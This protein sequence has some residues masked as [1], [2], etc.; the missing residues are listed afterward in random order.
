[1]IKTPLRW[2]PSYG[3]RGRLLSQ[4]G[5]PWSLPRLA[6]CGAGGCDRRGGA[7]AAV[8]QAATVNLDET[9]WRQE[10][11]RARLW[12]LVTAELTVF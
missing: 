10:Q 11:Q 4:P 12:T 8:Q 5:S 6:A 2:H 9:G 1:M 7:G 3:R